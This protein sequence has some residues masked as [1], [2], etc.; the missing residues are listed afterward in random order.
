MLALLVVFTNRKTCHCFCSLRG[1]M[2]WPERPWGNK[3]NKAVSNEEASFTIKLMDAGTEGRNSIRFKPSIFK[4]TPSPP[5]PQIVLTFRRDSGDISC[6]QITKSPF[7]G[8]LGEHGM[9]RPWPFLA[10]LATGRIDI[11]TASRISIGL[12]EY[13]SLGIFLADSVW[14]LGCHVCPAKQT[15]LHGLEGRATA[16]QLAEFLHCAV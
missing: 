5:S 16:I 4:S 8:N 3:A 12:E 10:A 11:G 2:W 13:G 15:F 6:Q 9:T 7:A 1:R 14:V